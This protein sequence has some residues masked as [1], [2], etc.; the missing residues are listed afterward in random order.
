MLLFKGMARTQHKITGELEL[1]DQIRRS[2]PARNRSVRLGIG[3]DCAILRPR[4]G[5]EVLVTTD[6]SIEGRHFRRELHPA[7]SVGHRCLARGLSDLAAMGGNRL[8]LFFR[9]HCRRRFFIRGLG[10]HGWMAFSWGYAVWQG[11]MTRR[12]LVGIP[13]S[14]QGSLFLRTLSWWVRLRRAG[15]C[16][17]ARRGLEMR[18]TSQARWVGRML[19]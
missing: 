9:W 16:A 4:R 7:E 1:I 3:D 15:H 11:D 19:S 2:F 18:S 13:R 5:Q 6:F 8:R 14:L 10:R 17:A 12:W